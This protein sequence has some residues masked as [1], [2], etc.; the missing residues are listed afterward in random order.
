[1][2]SQRSIVKKERVEERT[3]G[4]SS[5]TKTGDEWQEHAMKKECWVDEEVD[6][7]P[8]NRGVVIVRCGKK[9]KVIRY[10]KNRQQLTEMSSTTTTCSCST[11]S[12]S[13]CSASCSSSAAHGSSSCSG[14]AGV[15][16]SSTASPEASVKGPLSAKAGVQA[17]S[18]PSAGAGVGVL[19]YSASLQSVRPSGAGAP[20]RVLRR[21]CTEGC[22]GSREHEEEATI[23]ISVASS[24]AANE[25]KNRRTP[26]GDS[27]RNS[28]QRRICG[29]YMAVPQ[30]PVQLSSVE[31]RRYSRVYPPIA[32]NGEV[33]SFASKSSAVPSSSSSSISFPYPPVG[34]PASS[35][36][37]PTNAIGYSY[38]PEAYVPTSQAFAS[39]RLCIAP[40][41]TPPSYINRNYSFCS[42]NS[43]QS[44]VSSTIPRPTSSIVS[45]STQSS[46]PYLLLPQ[47]FDHPCQ[48][49]AATPLRGLSG[50]NGAGVLTPKP[51][52]PV[53]STL[54]Y[55][56]YYYSS[57]SSVA[58]PTKQG[59]GS[60]HVVCDP[61]IPYHTWS[62]YPSWAV[63]SSMLS[64]NKMNM[65]QGSVPRSS[66]TPPPWDPMSLRGGYSVWP[67][68]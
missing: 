36:P 18:H 19:S 11:S 54:P 38:T 15:S 21:M 44:A 45:A 68:R 14:G 13:S 28:E 37:P 20:G 3:K 42:P 27:A 34:P 22:E 8:R 63:G 32:H 64:S 9:K 65:T 62:R 5:A 60:H 1:M 55:Y 67:K 12:C 29:E 56:Y 40:P 59:G 43:L 24:N 57:S 33:F 50:G 31:S 10:I 53:L 35:V 4:A 26:S 49:R 17:T 46:Q 52:P 58:T 7:S 41:I 47:V 23:A 51:S 16:S 25:A 66:I 30:K 48:H 6:A 2:G 39:T 61:T